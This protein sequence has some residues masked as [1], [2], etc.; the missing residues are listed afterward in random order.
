MKIKM[1]AFMLMALISVSGMAG[2]SDSKAGNDGTQKSQQSANPQTNDNGFEKYVEFIGL[3]KESLIKQIDEEPIIIDEGGLNF[4]KLGIRTWFS[5][6]SVS[7][8]YT[9]ST[10][11]D[12]DGAKIGDSIDKFK[13]SFRAPISDRNGDMHFKYNN[14]FLSV[15]YDTDTKKTVA[16]YILKED[17]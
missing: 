2:C 6:G 15:N 1:I 11:V 8:I 10:N 16:V 17:F 13:E 5:D 14:V 12:F 4:S 7:Q 9:Q 3:D